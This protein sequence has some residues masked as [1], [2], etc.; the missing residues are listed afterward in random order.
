M[1]KELIDKIK[2]EVLPGATDLSLTVAG[3]P[4]MTPKIRDFVEL[5]KSCD[6]ELQLNTNA[7]LIKD[8][9]LL[10]DVL[11]QSSVLKISLDGHGETY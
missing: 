6:V 8:S 4:F 2:K 7:T 11:K 9:A 3:E 10:K 5:A 1:S